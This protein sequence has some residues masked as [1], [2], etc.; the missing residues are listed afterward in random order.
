MELKPQV[1][2]G[3]WAGCSHSL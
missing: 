2:K 3:S 1:K